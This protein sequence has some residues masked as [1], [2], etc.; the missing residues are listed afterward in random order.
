MKTW[1]KVPTEHT[2]LLRIVHYLMYVYG[3]SLLSFQI[4]FYHNIDMLFECYCFLV[5]NAVY[6]G[7]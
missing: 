2:N 6:Y 4:I 7:R 3:L 5:C 1:V